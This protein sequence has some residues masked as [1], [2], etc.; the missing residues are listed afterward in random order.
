MRARNKY[1]L[2]LGEQIDFC[3]VFFKHHSGTG[4]IGKEAI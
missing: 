4:P 1:R 2:W 3:A